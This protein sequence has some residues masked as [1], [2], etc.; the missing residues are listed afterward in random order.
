MKHRCK[1]LLVTGGA[2]FIGSN[3]IDYM[4]DNYSDLNIYNFDLLT[5]AGNLKN[6]INFK[7]DKRYTF[8]KGDICNKELLEKIFNK[9][10][11]DG[12]VNFAAES[13]VDNS[14]KNPEIFINTN[15][16]GVFN[17]LTVAYNFWMIS[18][19]KIKDDFTNARFLQISTDEVY[20]SAISSSFSELSAYNPNS[21]YSASKAS[22]DMLVRSFSVTFG[23]NVVCTISSNNYGE[24]QHKEKFIPKI[25]ECIRKNKKIPVYGNGKNIRDWI[26]VKDNCKAIDLVFNN[27]VS[28]SKYNIGSNNELSN[29]QLI[30]KI[31]N[32]SGK[33][34]DI[35]FI[36]D[37]FG[38]DFRYSLDTSKIRK[39]LNWKVE[40]TLDDY[41][42]QNI[43]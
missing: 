30:E 20:G 12:I 26:Y 11:I 21:P 31:F 3:F 29:I 34:V 22:A 41:I 25:F 5:Y 14:I 7:N 6:T 36:N 2:G 13:H 8:I 4:L 32:I 23:L 40:Y 10:K 24:N 39:D 17:L 27:A 37:R 15:I 9:Y 43:Q 18:P 16:N 33:K 38:H 1:N 19:H 28:G 42:S 35:N